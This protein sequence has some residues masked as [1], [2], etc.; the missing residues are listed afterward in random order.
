VDEEKGGIWGLYKETWLTKDE[1]GKLVDK[2]KIWGGRGNELTSEGKIYEQ[3][4]TKRLQKHRNWQN[5][6]KHAG[7]T[8]KNE[9]KTRQCETLFI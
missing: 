7:R 9:A 5:H 1:I 8:K 6:R 4:E 3:G 2:G